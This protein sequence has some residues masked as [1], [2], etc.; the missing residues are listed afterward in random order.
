MKLSKRKEECMERVRVKKGKG[1]IILLFQEI[2]KIITKKEK[3]WK[4]FLGLFILCL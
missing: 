4:I 3:F 1:I 2:K